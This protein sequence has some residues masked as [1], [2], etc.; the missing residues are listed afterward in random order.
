[1]GAHEGLEYRLTEIGGWSAPTV[2]FGVAARR[3]LVRLVRGE[4]INSITTSPSGK[5]KQ[6]DWKVSVAAKIKASRGD[7]PWT[8][9]DEYAVTLCMRFFPGYHGNRPLDVENFI[10]PVLD[11][12]AAGLFCSDDTDPETIEHWGYDDSN[13]RTLLIHRFPDTSDPHE[14]GVAIVV[15]AR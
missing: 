13:F 10:K 11:A 3:R 5:R 9:S 1:M 14:E 2:E 6:R 12:V 15:S 8:P 7:T 4:I